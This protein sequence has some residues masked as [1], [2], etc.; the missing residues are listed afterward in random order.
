MARTDNASVYA[1]TQRWAYAALVR[2]DSL[3]AAG[4]PIWTLEVINDF[5]Q[6]FV[7]QPD[8][9]NDPFMAKFA[10][11][12]A[13]AS[14]ETVQLAAEALYVYYLIAANIKGDTKRD[15]IR[16][17]LS[18]AGLNTTIP[19]DLDRAL[20]GDICN[21]WT[22]FLHVHPAISSFRQIA[23]L[24]RNWKQQCPKISRI[25]KLDRPVE[26]FKDRHLCDRR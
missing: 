12:L 6:R 15:R 16:H 10:R 14:A 26:V 24:A 3:F 17:L 19:K 9:S 23:T 13:G 7:G 11:Q 2:D 25:P 4:S 21:T 1:A 22:T 5:H 8:A 18:L 20:D